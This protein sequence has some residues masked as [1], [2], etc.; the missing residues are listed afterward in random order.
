MSTHVS[1]RILTLT[2]PLT[3]PPVQI[4]PAE[5]HPLCLSGSR[6]V[7][8]FGR[9]DLRILSPQTRG[10]KISAAG[11]ENC[12][13]RAHCFE[14]KFKSHLAFLVHTLQRGIHSKV[15]PGATVSLN[16]SVRW[17]SFEGECL[18]Q[19][20]LVYCKRCRAHGRVKWWDKMKSQ[21]AD[22]KSRKPRV[23]FTITA[24]NFSSVNIAVSLQSLFLITQS[25]LSHQEF[26]L[27]SAKTNTHSDM[28]FYKDVKTDPPKSHFTMTTCQPALKGFRASPNVPKDDFLHLMLS[29]MDWKQLGTKA[30]P[31]PSDSPSLDIN[32]F[33][34]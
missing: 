33:F 30:R 23:K 32:Y 20:L 25:V 4:F 17:R 28:I 29:V 8:S 21:P 24:F 16:H 14:S 1:S 12:I 3:R 10:L 7:P 6:A 2:R 34:S 26:D 18:L 5:W 13:N 19:S 22:H 9:N 31:I 27:P 15:P 11:R